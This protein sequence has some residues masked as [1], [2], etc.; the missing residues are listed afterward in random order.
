MTFIVSCKKKLVCSEIENNLIPPLILSDISF[1][2]NRCR[3]RCFDF[4]EWRELSMDKCPQAYG[5]FKPSEELEA[6]NERELKNFKAELSKILST[7][8]PIEA[9]DGLAGFSNEDMALEIKPRIKRLN[10][11]KND[12]C[13]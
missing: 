9:C 10:A 7:D 6:M 2:F 5:Y 4:N 11:I 1:Q 13:E 8:L 12:V 3:I